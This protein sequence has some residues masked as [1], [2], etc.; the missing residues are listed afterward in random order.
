[1]RSF[2]T[3]ANLIL[4]I[5]ACAASAS[6]SEKYWPQWRGPLGSGVAPQADPPLTWGE[7][8]NIKWK[9]AVPGEGDATPIVWGDR[10]FL[11]SAVAAANESTEAGKEKGP[12]GTYRFTVF[13]VDRNSGKILW[14]KVARETSPHE[15][16][17]DNNTFASASPVTDGKLVWAF[18]GSRG[19]YC[20][21]FDGNLKWQK[22]LGLMKTKMGFGEGASPALS[23]DTLIINWDHEGDDFIAAFDK[24]SGKELWRQ[25]RNEPTGWSTPLVVEFNGQKQV[26]VNATEKVRSYDLATGKE[27]WSCGGQTANAIPSPVAQNDVVYVTSGFRGNALQA[28]RLGRSGDLT[29]TDAIVWS[30]NKSTPYIPSPVLSENYLYVISGNENLI[31]CF[32]AKTGEP[33]F[34]RER[35]EGIRG[36]YASPVSA[37]DR[38]YVLGRE[39]TCIV[40]KKGPK[41]EVLAANKLNDSRS[42]ASIAL[43]DNQLLLRTAHNL[44]CISEK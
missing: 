35:L 3:V 33:F 15:G 5:G 26:V 32:D 14:Q 11:L 4:C 40:L 19:L 7:S 8:N 42:D 44:Y 12:N 10:I 16:H 30:R 37:K 41:L 39:G 17:Q 6:D 22:D 23:G 13:C 20:Y 34:E 25:P 27:L 2:K 18:F 28:I 29:G 43:V 1:M 31:S 21:D 24:T 9:L 36:I 38:V